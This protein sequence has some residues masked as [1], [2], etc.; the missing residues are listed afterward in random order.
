[1]LKDNSIRLDQATSLPPIFKDDNASDFILSSLQHEMKVEC[2]VL[3]IDWNDGAFNNYNISRNNDPTHTKQTL[4]NFIK[5]AGGHDVCDRHIVF[6]FR[7]EHDLGECIY[8][9]P[10]WYK[11]FF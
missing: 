10:A 8:G 5:N 7:T 3:V 4:I 9:L 11:K 6:L 2:P 1:M